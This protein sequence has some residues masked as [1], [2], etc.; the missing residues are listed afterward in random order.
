M[1]RIRLE[2]INEIEVTLSHTLIVNNKFR[3]V[4]GK[5]PLSIAVSAFGIDEHDKVDSG[6]VFHL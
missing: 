1:P 3:I 4:K 2:K 5:E 6:G